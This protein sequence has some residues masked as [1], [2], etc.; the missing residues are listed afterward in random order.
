MK[1]DYETSP[2]CSELSFA[3]SGGGRNSMVASMY[4]L[5][6]EYRKSREPAQFDSALK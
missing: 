6:E 4:A 5:V 1:E 2:T 3:C